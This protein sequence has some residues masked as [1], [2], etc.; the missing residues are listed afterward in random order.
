M[1]RLFGKLRPRSRSRSRSNP[2]DQRRPENEASKI[3]RQDPIEE[4]PTPTTSQKKFEKGP[5]KTKHNAYPA[6]SIG[7]MGLVQ[8]NDPNLNVTDPTKRYELDV[9]AMHGLNGDIYRTWTKSGNYWL[10]DQ[11]PNHLPGARIFSYGY[12]SDLIF[13]KSVATIDD[14]AIDLLNRLE[15]IVDASCDLNG[16]LLFP[17]RTRIDHFWI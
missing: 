6:P 17:V 16:F 9:I 1:R 4:V 14:F 2:P 10:Q 8:L 7:T 12:P 3:I 15:V 5:E 13:S 11:L